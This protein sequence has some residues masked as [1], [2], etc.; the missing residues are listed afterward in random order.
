[1]TQLIGIGKTS[2]ISSLSNWTDGSNAP[3]CADESPFN[4]WSDWDAGQRE[5]FVLDPDGNL[6]LHQNITSGIPD[7]LYE[8]IINTLESRD[9]NFFPTNFKLRPNYPNPFNSGTTIEY[10]VPDGLDPRFTIYDMK[11]RVIK[12]Y[13]IDKQNAQF[14]YIRW[15]GLN[16]NGENVPTGVYLYTIQAGQFSQTMK[17]LFV[18]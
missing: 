7:D 15:D 16:G 17:M 2:H 11:G 13:D 6:L 14:K 5:L 10:Q 18:K 8:L 9:R 3:V 4:V 1:M 12:S